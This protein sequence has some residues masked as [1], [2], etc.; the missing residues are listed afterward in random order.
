MRA[1]LRALLVSLL[2]VSP[3][4]AQQKHTAMLEN[5]NVYSGKNSAAAGIGQII[6]TD[7]PYDFSFNLESPT[8]ADSGKWK[9]R[10]LRASNV[11]EIACN[12]IGGGTASVNIEIRSV[13]TVAGTNILAAPIVCGATETISTTFAV[14]VIP[15]R[16]YLALAITAATTPFVEVH[17]SVQP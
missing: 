12:T 11:V 17:M 15:A 16:S 1:T 3:V 13:P 14:T 10:L 6:A 9:H 8:I 7:A 4:I 2:L 5:N